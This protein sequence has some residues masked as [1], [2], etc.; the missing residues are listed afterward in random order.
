MT[1]FSRFAAVVLTPFTALAAVVLTPLTALAAVVLTPLTTPAAVVPTPL[2]TP[3]AVVPTGAGR[4]LA[5]VEAAPVA[6][7]TP[8]ATLCTV[9][10]TVPASEVVVGWVAV[11]V[12]ELVELTGVLAV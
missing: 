5:T 7:V 6:W 3:A 10:D 9:V 2:T 4:L 12:D 11:R 8:P 1:P